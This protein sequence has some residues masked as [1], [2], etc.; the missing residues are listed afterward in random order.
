MESLDI[1]KIAEL[2]KL[3]LGET[4]TAHFQ[5]SLDNMLHFVNALHQ[6]NTESI[7]PL[8]HP[9]EITQ[10]LRVDA[11]TECSQ[12]EAMLSNAPRQAHDL[13]LVPKVVEQ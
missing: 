9:L 10:R 4:E 2:A 3:Q 7:E 6:A 5:Q 11:V 13:F 1:Q 12:V 8:A